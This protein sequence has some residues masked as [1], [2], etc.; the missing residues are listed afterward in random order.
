VLSLGGEA[1]TASGRTPWWRSGAAIT[2]VI[3][4]VVALSAA[5]S[6]DVV[7]A[8][9]K[10][11][12]D[13]AT[14]VAMTLSMAYDR[15]LKYERRDLE[16]FW[17]I[18]QTG[19]EGIFL[20]RGKN[21]RVRFR[22]QPP[23]V[24]LYNDAAESRTDRLFFGKAMIYSV[25]AAPFVWLFGM[26]GFYVFHVLLVFGA[27][28]CGYLFL[29]ARSP[30]TAA[31]AFTVA[32]FAASVIPV[33]MVFLTSDFF[34][35]ALVFAAYF[36][37]LYKEVAEPRVPWLQSPAADVIA[38]VL[39]GAATYSKV[40]NAP[41]VAP[42][43]LLAWWRRRWRDGFTVGLVS[44]AA[45]AML[46]TAN[47]L[48]SGEFNYQGGDRKMFYSSAQGFPFEK[49]RPTWDE[50]AS[51]VGTDDLGAQDSLVPS[52]MLRMFPLNVKYFLFGRHFGFVPYFF[53]GVV[54]LLA[55][56]LSRHRYQ[57][58]RIVTFTG[59]LVAT[60]LLLIIFPY[61]WSGGGGPPGNRYFLSVYPALFYLMPPVETAL[62]GLLAWLGGALFTAKMLVNP[63]VAA[64]F[65]WETTER[66]WARRLPVELTMANDLPMRLAQPVRG[67]ILY[68]QPDNKP[69]VLLYFLDQHAY[70]PEPDGMWI[71]GDGRA[72]VIV[73]TDVPIDH[74]AV[75][76]YT[77]IDTVFSVSAG[78]ETKTIAMKPLTRVA[79]DLKVSGVQGFRTNWYYL[80]KAQST[81]GF[82]PR[83]QDPNLRDDRNL[84][85]QMKFT[86]IVASP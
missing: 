6:V 20:K 22:T 61:T 85:V 31:L 80:L 35:F 34:N 71:A 33:H 18:Y 83:L 53:P 57:P 4:L 50:F 46:F 9:Y 2:A 49:P 37:W 11:K 15:D 13:E 55:W 1:T 70:P 63:F 79:F 64:K 25:A 29:S 23:F 21:F 42:L 48:I 81:D 28:V 32:F 30:R 66:G 24:F 10:I 56:L 39:L 5:I 65:T 82:I 17:G 68:R 44:V 58:W 78:A 27:G 74:L 40:S 75:S 67:H 60:I 36:F 14:Y 84:G 7:R 76:L 16:R 47:A 73:R 59:L 12:G 26:N 41:L 45:C 38:A 72:E 8:G 51:S 52:E 19:P 86:A 69:T 54:A 62:P 43:V 3:L 77:S